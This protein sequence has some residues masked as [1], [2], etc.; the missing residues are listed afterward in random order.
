MVGFIEKNAN[1]LI[2]D[3]KSIQQESFDDFYIQFHQDSIFQKKR[4]LFPIQGYKV[5]EDL[6]GRTVKEKWTVSNW[7]ILKIP[8]DKID[9]L[10]KFTIIK[11]DTVGMTQYKTTRLWSQGVIIEKLWLVDS[12]FHFETRF[13]LVKGQWYLFYCEE[14]DM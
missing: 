2:T 3:I 14:V 11:N 1:E 4:L 6:T 5:S 9:T 7:V 8:I 10:P 12:G 13:K